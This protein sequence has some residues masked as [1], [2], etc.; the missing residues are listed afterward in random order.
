MLIST[1]LAQAET[2][3]LQKVRNRLRRRALYARLLKAACW[4]AVV[5]L[6][7]IGF[8]IFGWTAANIPAPINDPDFP[9]S[10]FIWTGAMVVVCIGSGVTTIYATFAF[11][12]ELLLPS[13]DARRITRRS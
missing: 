10:P 4:L 2:D 1:F 5:I 13:N 7:G 8:S 6:F 12:D 11:L 3:H 9:L